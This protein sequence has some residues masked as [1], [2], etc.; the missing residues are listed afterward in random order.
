MLVPDVG[1]RTMTQAL[2]ASPEPPGAVPAPDVAGRVPGTVARERLIRELSHAC[3]RPVVLIAAP[4]G[5]GKS[6]LLS[7]W[8]QYDPRPFAA[9]AARAADNDPRHLLE[10]IARALAAVAP[11]GEEVFIALA[12]PGGALATDLLGPFGRALARCGPFV[13]AI[14]DVGLLSA[15]E[16]LEALGAVADHIP[17]G[18][19]LALASRS[20]PALPIGRLRAQAR[21][22][23]LRARDLAMTRREAA[24]LLRMHGLDLPSDE[25]VALLRRTDGWPAGLLLAALAVQRAPDRGRAMRRF[26]GNNRLVADYLSDEVMA[27]LS[28]EHTRFVM[29][30]SIL[31]VLSG[32]VCDATLGTSG[33]GAVLR[34]LVRANVL[35]EPL[36]QADLEYR[37]HPLFAQMLRAELR[38]VEPAWERDLRR[39]AAAW[40][41]ERDD[42]DRAVDH[43]V[44]AGDAAAAGR[45]LWATAARQVLAGRTASLRSWLDRFSADQQAGDPGL[46][47]TAAA[48]H[49]VLGERD[50]V[51]HWA[52]AAQ[53]ALGSETVA[54]DRQAL[55]AG[56]RLMRATVA[57][58]GLAEM[59]EDAGIAYALAA[60]DSP[61]RSLSCLLSGVAA[62][63]IGERERA[64]THLQ[65]GA[66][67]GAISAPAVQVLCLAQLALMAIDDE[68]WT[69][70]AALSSRSRAQADRVGLADCPISALA[71]A[72]SARVHAQR[73]RAEPAQDDRRAALRLLERLT[74]FVPWYAS[75]AR[76]ALAGA[77][78]R[79]GDVPAMRDLLAQAVGVAREIP[80]AVVLSGWIEQLRTTAE[81][82]ADSAA[83][84]GSLTTAELRVLQ[85]LPTHLS[86]REIADGLHVSANTI[87]THAHAVYRKLDAC[88]R[89]EAVERAREAGLLG[90]GI[91]QLPGTTERSLATSGAQPDALTVAELRVLG[92]LPS[93]LS[94]A[95]IGSR[96]RVSVSTVNARAEAAYRKLAAC[97]RAEAV[98]RARV[99]G[100]LATQGGR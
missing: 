63:L 10:S 58:D 29:G 2:V 92:L 41:A 38:R 20:D 36:D 57:R 39:R 96:L 37:Y 28:S 22:L 88:S 56:V 77:A 70:A 61:W 91:D 100:L 90:D 5:Y 65:E 50:L 95:E 53:R 19:Q 93:D 85:L 8:C 76:L 3:D 71:F 82:L 44:A 32:P 66:R 49:L 67:R 25:V 99:V 17:P 55:D 69:E 33:S 40:Y 27:G 79:L 89:S 80:E 30:T 23:E 42:L 86:F 6:T 11:V 87:K 34:D 47:L 4:A 35:L 94:L 54:A 15:P 59:A 72:V 83:A 31:D 64:R 43:A 7:Q 1:V 51:E 26:G 75:E 21:L 68:D 78:L 97:S 84:P 12:R 73:G 52:A 62:H 14:D 48:T 98:E 74:D 18:S 46:A 45:F 24:A 13:L 81:T 60:E 9:I 16:A